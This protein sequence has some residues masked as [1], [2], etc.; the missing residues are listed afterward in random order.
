MNNNLQK[1][2]TIVVIWSLLLATIITIFSFGYQVVI[3]RYTHESNNKCAQDDTEDSDI[4][5]YCIVK[6]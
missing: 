4:Q 3:G 6:K 1:K 5:E 2:A